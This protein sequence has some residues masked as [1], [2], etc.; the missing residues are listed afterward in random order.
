MLLWTSAFCQKQSAKKSY[1]YLT[2]FEQ[3]KLVVSKDSSFILSTNQLFWPD[4]SILLTG[5]I[6]KHE[7]LIQFIT[8]TAKL[9]DK[10]VFKQVS[11]AKQFVTQNEKVA[12]FKNFILFKNAL[13]QAYNKHHFSSTMH[14]NYY[15]GDGKWTNLITL[16]KDNTYKISE[17]VHG[18]EEYTE[19]GKWEYKKNFIRFMPAKRSAKWL[20]KYS[21]K[22]RFFI[23]DNFLIGHLKVNKTNETYFYFCKEPI[24][25]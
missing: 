1:D 18:E 5:K 24:E 13:R 8:D 17:S 21:D 14:G 20:T 25:Y 4:T 10:E 23:T 3:W 16:N 19:I 22:R 6:M 7:T 15:R 12:F 9:K 2:G 11:I